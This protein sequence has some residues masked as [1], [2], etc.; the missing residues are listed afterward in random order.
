MEE[1][2][3]TMDPERRPLRADAERNRRRLIESATAIFCERGL[4]VGVG[5]IAEQAGVG[6]GTLFRNFPCKE[7]LIAAVVVARIR[8]SVQRG[9]ALLDA[10]DPGEALFGLIDQ[11][12][13][14]SQTDRALFDALDDAWLTNDEIRAAHS[15]LLAVVDGLVSRAQAAGAVRPD[16][17]AVDVLMMVKGVCESSRSFQH[18]D[19]NAAARQ[20]DLVWAA[21]AT[22]AAQRGLRGQAPTVWVL[23]R[24][25]PPAGASPLKAAEPPEPSAPPVDAPASVSA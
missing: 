17:S 14:R 8:E 21:I 20:L 10:A 23:E 15:E 24:S 16:V 19:P 13:A 1:N 3:N 7:D 12:A 11:A 9:Q 4:E 6:R 18:V 25:A 2:L 22:P 5:E